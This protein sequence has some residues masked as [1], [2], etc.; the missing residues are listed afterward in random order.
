MAWLA[1][2]RGRLCPPHVGGSRCTTPV[3]SAPAYLTRRRPATVGTAFPPA[4]SHAT[5]R[6]SCAP[7]QQ[8]QGRTPCARPAHAPIP[9]KLTLAAH[10]PVGCPQ[11]RTGRSASAVATARHPAC[12]VNLAGLKTCRRQPELGPDGPQ[13]AEV[14][15]R[16]DGGRKACGNDHLDAGTG[17]L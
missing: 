4:T 5:P 7:P 9:S 3:G 14:F 6:R 8:L 2:R 17:H 13:V 16:L 15:G 10:A 12:P 11:P 1:F